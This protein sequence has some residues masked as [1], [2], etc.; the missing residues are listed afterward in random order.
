MAQKFIFLGQSGESALETINGN[1][2]EL[3]ASLNPPIK[4]SNVSGDVFQAI[5][6]N[7]F[8]TNI[9]LTPTVG[10]PTLR[11][12]ITPGGSELLDD[13]VIEFMQ[14]INANQLF[15]V[16]GALYFTFSGSVGA[17][18]IR[19]DLIPNFN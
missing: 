7:T 1:F 18:D 5:Q 2:F 9:Y 16:I 3:Y 19:I 11:V 8:V 13:T 12:G 4:A 6:A 17:I 10:T 15:T 14:P